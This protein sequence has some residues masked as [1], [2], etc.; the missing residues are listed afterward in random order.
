MLARF[1]EAQDAEPRRLNDKPKILS[2]GTDRGRD[3]E[4]TTWETSAAALGMIS[5][6]LPYFKHGHLSCVY[7]AV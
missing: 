3:K 5:R 4:C 1:P 2:T 7:E 6:Q